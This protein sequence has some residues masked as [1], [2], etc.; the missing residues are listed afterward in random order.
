MEKGIFVTGSDTG[1]GKTVIA[2]AIA[3][4]AKAHGLD[5]G[6]MKP[7]ATGAKEIDGKL[8]S[9]DAM[10]LKKIIECTDDDDLVNPIR[11]EP[12]LAPTISLSLCPAAFHSSLPITAARRFL[13]LLSHNYCISTPYFGNSF[14]C[15]FITKASY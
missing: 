6:V 10:Y 12:A 9:L 15:I 3:A 8:I 5:T 1:V 7:V 2:A 4:A 11:F 13:P 14:P